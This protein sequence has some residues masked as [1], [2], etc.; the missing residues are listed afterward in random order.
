MFDFNTIVTLLVLV[1]VIYGFMSAKWSM[2]IVA[3][4]GLVVLEITKVLTF[5]EAF[6]YL[7]SNNVV[8]VAACFILSGALQK[9]S[10]VTKL[11]RWMLQHANNGTMVV[12]MYLFACFIL[13]QFVMPTA[14]V[15]ML[16]P[17]MNALDKDSKVQ[18]SHLLFPGVVTAHAAQSS[19]PL[20]TALT[21]FV[22]VNAI[23]EANGWTGA[24]IGPFSTIVIAFP[25]AIAVYLYY[26][27]IGWKLYPA[28]QYDASAIKEY[29]EKEITIT[30]KQETLIYVV[31]VGTMLCIVL[32][33]VWSGFPTDLYIIAII[34]DVILCLT[35]VMT[36]TDV[37]NSMNIDT[38]FM[39]VGVLPLATAMQKSNAA[40][41]V[42]DGIV[43]LLG[44]NPSYPVFLLAFMIVGGVLTQF[45]SNS[46]TNNVFR[47]LAII[48][49]VSL[50][51]DAR[52]V[53]IA[54]SLM[55]TAA[56]LTPM[57]SPSL[58]IAYGA[59][60]YTQKELLKANL[61]A[62]IIHTAIVFGMTLIFYH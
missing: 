54:C 52:G 30:K 40:T 55:T 23:L 53:A 12:A 13:V 16:L 19:L 46:A 29:K 60:G 49:A 59:G 48:T 43:T 41:I 27:F 51:F 37:R 15:S 42:A 6:A 44:G 58:S 14:L 38:L 62:W 26:V 24:G 57:G 4:T 33:S 1:W 11:R 61:P 3:M 45:M 35:K 20:G 56:M 28:R 2:G 47:P 5:E 34:A 18:P 32:K 22:T 21:G 50:G 10:L 8:M 17:F 31:F 39:L 9:T 25:A 36:P 7:S